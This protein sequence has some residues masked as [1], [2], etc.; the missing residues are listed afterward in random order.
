MGVDL[1]TYR[2]R[3]G[4]FVRA[5]CS[6]RNDCPV[7][8]QAESL[9][10]HLS[11]GARFSLVLFCLAHLLV[12]A[13]DVETN[14]GPE[15]L[16][17]VLTLVKELIT[18]NHKFQEEV[19]G[20]LKD[21]QLSVTDI[22]RRLSELEQSDSVRDLRVDVSS[23]SS[24]LKESC[25]QLRNIDSRQT[26]RSSLVVDDLDNRIRRNNLIFKG[27]PETSPETWAETEE[28][29]T[30]F[31]SENLDIDVGEIERAHRIGE[32]KEGTVR[33]VV[34]KFLNFKDKH[35][36]LKNASKLKDVLAPRVWIEED[37]SPRMQLIR[38]QLR[39]FAH[40]TK[41]PGEKYKVISDKLLLNGRLYHLDPVT[42]GV[43]PLPRRGTPATEQ[44]ETLL[45]ESSATAA[46]EK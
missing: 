23:V 6:T 40:A 41:Q 36:I 35:N 33:P 44:G 25:D 31:V 14:P 26:Q 15:K 2:I 8:L 17:Q 29:I 21:L 37:F 42:N 16:D 4:C 1:C 13:G 10:R 3:V 46:K 20:R 32:W 9:T 7:W 27:L 19:S 34:V 12:C 24:L 43:V 39:D 5:G 38:K 30:K 28:T 11:T 18:S 22:K 45:E